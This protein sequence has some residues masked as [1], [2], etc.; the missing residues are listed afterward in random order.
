MYCFKVMDDIEAKLE[1]DAGGENSDSHRIE[2][3]L[4]R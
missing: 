2:K 4:L 3:Y 1:H